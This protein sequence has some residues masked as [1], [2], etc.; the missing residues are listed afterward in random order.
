MEKAVRLLMVEDVA[1]DAELAVRELKRAG[2]RVTRRV[3]DTE[4]DFRKALAEFAPELILSD[5]GLPK[6]DG[7]RALE[8]AREQFPATPFIFVSGSIGEDYAIRALRNGATDYVLK[9]NL[10]RLPVAVQR[11]LQ[12]ARAIAD[13][14][15][16]ERALSANEAGLRRAQAMAGL[17]HIVSRPPRCRAARAT[18]WS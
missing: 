9:S 16:A 4:D 6:F 14:R 7:M 17:G 2:L 1:T 10:M 11:A 13:K 18:G 5:F 3:V 8:I 15:A 12:D